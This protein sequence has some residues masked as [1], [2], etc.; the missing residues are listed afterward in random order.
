MKP[1]SQSRD[2][3]AGLD[4][5]QTAG[6]I[7]DTSDV[8]IVLDSAGVV[9]DVALGA[10]D[11]PEDLGPRWV[12]RPFAAAVT[13]ESRDK[14]EQMLADARTGTPARW[15]HL[16]HPAPSGPDLPILYRCVPLGATSRFLL[17]G[18]DLRPTAQLQQR[19]IDAQQSLERDYSRLRHVE[20]R[21]RL[22]FQIASDPILIVDAA[23]Q[24][25]LEANPAAARRLGDDERRL[26][27]RTFPDGFDAEGRRAIDAMLAG[28]RTS[29]RPD[30][31][32]VKLVDHDDRYV[33]SASLFR[34]E[35]AA[36]FLVRVAPVTTAVAHSTADNKILRAIAD[37]PDAFVLTAADGRILQANAAFVDLA[38]L[39]NP[40]QAQGQSLDRWV[41]RSGVDLN[42]MFANLR[43]RGVVKLFATQLRGEYG[44]TT[45]VEV[46]AVAVVDGGKPSFGFL[47]RNVG[48]RLQAPGG[49]PMALPR[50]V[51]QL[52]ELVGRVSLKELVRETTD[53]I[54]RLYIEAALELTGNNR[55]SAAELL[56]LSRQSLYVKLHRY[57]LRDADG[58][59]GKGAGAS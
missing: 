40:E 35:A 49:G 8:A 16:N 9:L 41:G 56:G 48:R 37:A 36:L 24:K 14:V 28:V 53:M 2:T 27:G 58:D 21:Y 17:A 15:R 5:A 44:V 13:E 3:L 18:R 46:S 11:L 34:Q 42:V 38:Q 52:T 19:L 10:E 23:T 7:A 29:G 26:V 39:A 47:I 6:V 54:E 33:V 4:A 57:G 43:E 32:N 1:F 20:T 25:V 50:S 31:V 30:D 45:D 59:D 12:G 55:A 51:D 22:L